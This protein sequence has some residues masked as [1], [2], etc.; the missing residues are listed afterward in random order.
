MILSNAI[1]FSLGK[2]VYRG[3][4]FF[5]IF[6]NSKGLFYLGPRTLLELGEYLKEQADE[7]NDDDTLVNVFHDCLLCS[8]IISCGSK[9]LCGNND[10]K[11][12]YH[13]YCIIEYSKTTGKSECPK[14][15]TPIDNSL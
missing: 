13:H 8:S 2:S 12:K 6:S 5:I 3:I 10:C 9:L 15:Q 14:C 1:G 7:S 11:L 4:H